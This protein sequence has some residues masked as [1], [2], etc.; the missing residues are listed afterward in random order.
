L[1]AFDRATVE[2]GDWPETER[3]NQIIAVLKA[4]RRA[5]V[6]YPTGAGDGGHLSWMAEGL[7]QLLLYRIVALAEGCAMCWNGRNLLG[8]ILCARRRPDR[9]WIDRW[10]D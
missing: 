10:R 5:E 3:N 4:R 7:E 8:A 1:A 9:L 2:P 6:K